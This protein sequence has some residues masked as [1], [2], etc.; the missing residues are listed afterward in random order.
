MNLPILKMNKHAAKLALNKQIKRGKSI[1]ACKMESADEITAIIH[2]MNI[3]HQYNRDLLIKMFDS[4]TI[5]DEY[6]SRGAGYYQANPNISQKIEWINDEIVNQIN[7]LK[8]IHK[9]LDL[10]NDTL[11][12]PN[13]N[14]S[15]NLFQQVF[16]V[17]GHN[18]KIKY[19]VAH[20]IEKLELKSTILHEEDN[21]G[22]HLLN[23][24]ERH[25]LSSGFAIVILS[26]D[27]KGRSIKGKNIYQLRARQNV[28]FELGY[29]VHA[30]G[31]RNIFILC[32]DNVEIP[33]DLD[34]LVY[35]IYDEKGAWKN[36]L[37]KELRSAGFSVN[38][39]NL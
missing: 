7:E 23:K 16:I 17:H 12:Q 11:K 9:R 29:F 34:G 35:V 19:E 21:K 32:E 36:T 6:Y 30:L 1:L 5:S 33:S 31:V 24:F 13:K 26:A 22:D 25:A 18:D 37:A 4:S 38:T 28:I 27:D 15:I 3:W 10:H 2:N 20:T 14:N 39:N 8:S